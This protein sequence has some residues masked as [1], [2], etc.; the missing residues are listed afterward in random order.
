MIRFVP[1]KVHPRPAILSVPFFAA[2]VLSV[3]APAESVAPDSR[4]V[5]PLAFGGCLL[6]T[7]T[8]SNMFLQD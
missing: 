7:S 6:L 8:L 5:K 3:I 1:E 2:S 4:R